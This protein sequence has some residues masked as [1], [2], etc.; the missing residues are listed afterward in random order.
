MGKH[1]FIDIGYY[2]SNFDLNKI[3]DVFFKAKTISYFDVNYYWVDDEPIYF[4]IGHNQ[5][6]SEIYLEAISKYNNHK[7]G[8]NLIFDNIITYHNLNV[9]DNT[10]ITIGIGQ[11][12]M[13]KNLKV[14]DF[15]YYT[16]KILP[17]FSMYEFEKIEFSYF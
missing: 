3:Y 5:M 17:I 4:N 2:D 1:A 13:I 14:P 11:P 12:K 6:M 15:T 9:N 10:Q 8:F 7:I 16:K